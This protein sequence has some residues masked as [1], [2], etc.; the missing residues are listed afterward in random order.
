MVKQSVIL[1]LRKDVKLALFPSIF[2]VIN[3]Y[4]AYCIKAGAFHKSRG[5]SWLFVGFFHFLI[6]G[7]DPQYRLKDSRP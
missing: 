3:I 6:S 7:D 2:L 1:S 4:I 5:I